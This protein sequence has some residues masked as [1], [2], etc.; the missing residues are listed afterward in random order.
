M[1][2]IPKVPGNFE[3]VT[4]FKQ[5]SVPSQEGVP[6]RRQEVI[7]LIYEILRIYDSNAEFIQ[8]IILQ[9]RTADP[10][11]KVTGALAV[12]NGDLKVFDGTNWTVVGTQT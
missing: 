12:V 11:I 4:D 1:A 6:L 2:K 9:N 7:D 10:D 3:K 8:P 5:D